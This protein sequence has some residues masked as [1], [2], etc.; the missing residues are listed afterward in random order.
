MNENRLYK[1]VMTIFGTLMVFF[2]L[3]FGIFL[4]S[5]HKLD[6]ILVKPLRVIVGSTLIFYGIYRAYRSYIQIVEVFFT[7][8]KDED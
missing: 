2:Y 5:S 3:G 8:E 6:Y 4:L 7:K 1:Q